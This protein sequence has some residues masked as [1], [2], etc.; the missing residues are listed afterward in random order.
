L[1]WLSRKIPFL[2]PRARSRSVLDDAQ[3]GAEW[4]AAALQK[5]G[6]RADF[7]VTSF[8]ELDRFFD[9]EAPGG[10]ARPGGLLSRNVG[11]H[12]FCLGAYCGEVVRRQIGGTWSVDEGDPQ[13]EIHVA[14]VLPDGTHIWPV[15][16]V[17]KR[18]RDGPSEGLHAYGTAILQEVG[19]RGGG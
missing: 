1:G 2:R 10:R 7:S 6:Y 9:A 5:A 17:M 12:L 19:K 8:R 4:I 15:Q 18:F 14:L 13:A 3:P 16:R 11:H